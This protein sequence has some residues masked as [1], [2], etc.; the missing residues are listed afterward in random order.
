MTPYS[1][2][3]LRLRFHDITLP[4]PDRVMPAAEHVREFLRFLDGW[5]ENDVL[6]IHCRAGISRSTAAAYIAACYL[7][8]DRDEHDLALELRRAS[9]LARPNG[10][11]VR[12]ADA[13]MSREGRMIEAIENTGRE[14]EWIEI[15]EANPFLLRIAGNPH[16]QDGP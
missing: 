11:L 1:G 14:L 13:E 7:H 3:H 16:T 6:L 15:D 10:T 4:M 5:D 12:L 2:R 9:P 8:P